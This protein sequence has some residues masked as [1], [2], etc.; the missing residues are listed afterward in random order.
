M[1]NLYETLLFQNMARRRGELERQQAED[2]QMGLQAQQSIGERQ[3]QEGQQR[4]LDMAQAQEMGSLGVPEEMIQGPPRVQEMA[5]LGAL[6]SLAGQ[7]ATAAGQE[8]EDM[9]ARMTQEGKETLQQRSL[10]A[11]IDRLG[12]TRGSIEDIARMN[13]EGMKEMYGPRGRRGAQYDPRKERGYADREQKLRTLAALSKMH[14]NAED[15]HNWEEMENIRRQQITLSRELGVPFEDPG[16][17]SFGDDPLTNQLDAL[18][19]RKEGL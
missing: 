2:V 7:R 8:R 3:Q 14:Q 18:I 4:M 1:A 12:I 19:Q 17:A 5:S 16:G 6:R 9:V 10:N 13:L 11:M 15:A